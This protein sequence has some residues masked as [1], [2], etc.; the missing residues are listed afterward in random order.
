MSEIGKWILSSDIGCTFMSIDGLSHAYCVTRDARV[1][2]LLDEMITVYLGIDKVKLKAQT[3]CTLTAARGMIRMYRETGDEVYLNGAKTIMSLYA[4]GGG[5]SLT[6]Q[7]LN[8]WGRPDSWTEPCAIVDSL[9][10]SG[11]LYKLTANE[12]YRTLAARIYHNGLST[13]QRDNGGAG[14]DSA[15]TE[16]GADTLQMGMYEAY[17][18]CT[19]RLSEG[20]WY[21]NENKELLKAQTTGKVEKTDFGVYMDGDI[22]Y[23][24][25]T[26]ADEY[27]C[28]ELIE[29]D[30]HKLHPLLKYF[31]IPRE[32][33]EKIS[34]KLIF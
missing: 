14:T 28:S 31:K 25:I 11:E 10:L 29:I 8:W 22:L 33:M 1:K 5:M 24:E 30:G 23:A 34:Q 19:M 20:L 9:M 7:N 32:D 27:L 13:A 21:I 15:V 16:G 3:H 2:E 26:G 6:Y 18:C 17:F 12:E 4:N